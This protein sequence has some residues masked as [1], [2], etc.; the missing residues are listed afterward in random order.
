MDPP[1]EAPLKDIPYDT[2][3]SN[4]ILDLPIEKI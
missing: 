2:M 1:W 3:A 4:E